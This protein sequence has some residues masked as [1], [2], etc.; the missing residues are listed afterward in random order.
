LVTVIFFVKK[1]ILGYIIMSIFLGNDSQ[2]I[3]STLVADASYALSVALTPALNAYTRLWI[4]L[5]NSMHDNNFDT[6]NFVEVG[7]G[8]FLQNGK[9][10]V[11]ANYD[12]VTQ[13]GY[14]N[15]LDNNEAGTMA[16][17][18]FFLPVV[19][20]KMIDGNNNMTT[21]SFLPGTAPVYLS[22]WGYNDQTVLISHV[23]ITITGVPAGFTNVYLGKAK[24]NTD[25]D[26]EMGAAVAITHNWPE[27]GNHLV[28]KQYVDSYVADLK[29]H[30][31][32]ILTGR[33]ND[34]AETQTL[35]KAL[36]A[37]LNRLYQVFFRKDRDE[38]T[39]VSNDEEIGASFEVVTGD[40]DDIQEPLVP[41][42]QAP[43][44]F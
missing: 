16:S 40:M 25:G 10:Y 23:A 1:F 13:T 9:E 8:R 39:I 6:G 31:D 33:T 32:A 29:E 38:E 30:Y 2:A 28:A 17:I 3:V 12:T 26:L 21:R 22:L 34:L 5:S 7:A 41:P 36:E 19:K 18:N 43:A 20:C 15:S 35:V 37:Q 4:T 42:D 11:Y 24:F 27:T 14:I 44:G